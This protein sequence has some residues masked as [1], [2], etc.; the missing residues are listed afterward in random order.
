MS[1]RWRGATLNMNWAGSS[2]SIL[3]S[4]ATFCG[5]NKKADKYGKIGCL[6]ALHTSRNYD[7]SSNEVIRGLLNFDFYI[8]TN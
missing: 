8:N 3:L 2:S 7:T 4:Q 6:A 5:G 1:D